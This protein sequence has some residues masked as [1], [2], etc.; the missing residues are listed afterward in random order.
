[1]TDNGGYSAPGGPTSTFPMYRTHGGALS[2][3]SPTPTSPFRGPYSPGG[4]SGMHVDPK[5]LI[6][7]PANELPEGVDPSQRE[8]GVQLWI[9]RNSKA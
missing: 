5:L 1:M 8:V 3:K 2:P 4:S 6:N 7:V 9:W